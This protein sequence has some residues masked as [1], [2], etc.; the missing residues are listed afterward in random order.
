MQDK[1]ANYGY[2]KAVQ[3]FYISQIDVY[4]FYFMEFSY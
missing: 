1:K 3:F 4:S 2:P